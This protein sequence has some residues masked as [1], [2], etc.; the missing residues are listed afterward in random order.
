MTLFVLHDFD[1][2]GFSILHTIFN[3]TRRY[4]FKVT[5][6][7]IDLGLRLADVEAMSL[8]SECVDYRG[9]DPRPNLLKSGATAAEVGFLVDESPKAAGYDDDDD[10]DDDAKKDDD[11]AKKPRFT[12]KRVELNAM[13]SAT[14]IDWLEGK[15]KEHGVAKLIPDKDDLNAAWKRAWRLAELNK[16][17]KEAEKNLPEPPAPPSNLL[18]QVADRLEEF[19]TLA[20]DE[21]LLEED[22]EA[23]KKAA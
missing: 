2:S 16:L 14:F 15:L 11:D 8:D 3:D 6:K 4:Q 12:G 9:T 5:P 18:Q 13:D 7:V 23:I 22:D 10:D 21:V 20:W 19:Q 17:I 1:K